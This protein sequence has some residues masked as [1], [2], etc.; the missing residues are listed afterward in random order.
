MLSVLDEFYS[1]PEVVA[2][3]VRRFMNTTINEMSLDK[4][5]SNNF[6]IYKNAMM[7]EENMDSGKFGHMTYAEMITL[8][9]MSRDNK[10]SYTYCDSDKVCTAERYNL[11]LYKVLLVN[12]TNVANRVISVRL[13][14][15]MPIKT[16]YEYIENL[17]K[18]NKTEQDIEP[19]SRFSNKYIDMSVTIN[20]L[21]NDDCDNMTIREVLMQAREKIFKGWGIVDC[22]IENYQE[23]I[24]DELSLV[25]N[26]LGLKFMEAFPERFDEEELRM[27]YCN[28]IE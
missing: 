19:D 13:F 21:H 4:M 15:E 14:L 8:I 6:S 20:R 26:I 7:E 9:E 11:F 24:L 25:R 2:S 12:I 10:Y 3:A 17:S 27:E 18:D 16:F 23:R 22:P 1:D 28:D 5:L